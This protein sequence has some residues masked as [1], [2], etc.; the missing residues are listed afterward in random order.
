MTNP[1]GRKKP[2]FDYEKERLGLELE[3]LKLEYDR[4]EMVLAKTKEKVHSLETQLKSKDEEILSLQVLLVGILCDS[5]QISNMFRK[6]AFD[7]IISW[8]D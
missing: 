1:Y 4:S 2:D 7:Q 8:S 6:K 3:L 5:P